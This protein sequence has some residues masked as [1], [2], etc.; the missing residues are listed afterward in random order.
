MVFM[1]PTR[2]PTWC[3][4]HH[5]RGALLSVQNRDANRG[6]ITVQSL[7]SVL[8]PHAYL[9]SYLYIYVYI[10][11]S[12]YIY[13]YIYIYVYIYICIYI[14]IYVCIYIY[15]YGKCLGFA[16]NCN[17]DRKRIIIIII[18]IIIKPLSKIFNECRSLT[19]VG[20]WN[21][22]WWSS[23]WNAELQQDLIGDGDRLRCNAWGNAAMPGQSP[24]VAYTFRYIYIYM[25]IDV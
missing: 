24:G 21:P 2:L 10:Y 18:I 1:N 4:L 8:F 20:D 3:Y 13:M 14:Y 16:R 17:Y 7:S 25:L 11:K 15:T 5:L 19:G 12:I 9:V 6:P 23:Q 22:V